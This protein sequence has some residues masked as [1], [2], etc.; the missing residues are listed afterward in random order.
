MSEDTPRYMC[1]VPGCPG[2]H[3]SKY[4]CCD[5][6]EH[7]PGKWVPPLT[8]NR[9]GINIGIC[10]ATNYRIAWTHFPEYADAIVERLNSSLEVE[11]VEQPSQVK[12]EGVLKNPTFVECP[13]TR[14]PYFMDLEHP[15]R[16]IV[17]TFGGPFDSYTIPEPDED[18]QLRSERFDHDRG[19]WIEGGEPL[20]LWIVEEEPAVVNTKLLR[21][22][23]GLPDLC[24]D[25]PPEGW[26]TDATRCAD[27]PRA[28]AK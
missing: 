7:Q 18:C 15:E 28:T 5:F 10:D 26:P 2:E 21:S 13:I 23:V 16:G 25:C 3:V 24:S 8:V 14:R 9:K 11:E 19:E 22:R 12:S 6:P 17:P 27:C 20:D 1:D 4:L